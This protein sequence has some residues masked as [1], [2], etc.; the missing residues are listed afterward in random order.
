MKVFETGAVS[1]QAPL[2]SETLRTCEG[3]AA[4]ARGSWAVSSE[5][6]ESGVLFFGIVI[7]SWRG[8][9]RGLRG[10]RGVDR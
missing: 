6:R 4:C 7:F 1:A 3:G 8:G 5:R 10:R 9:V 2:V